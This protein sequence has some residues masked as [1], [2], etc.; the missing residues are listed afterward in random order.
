[1]SR[2]I[3]RLLVTASGLILVCCAYALYADA[4]ESEIVKG[5]DLTAEV[6]LI[7][8]KSGS[9]VA[10]KRPRTRIVA[11]QT[12]VGGTVLFDP[13]AASNEFEGGRIWVAV[14]DISR[15]IEFDTQERYFGRLEFDNLRKTASSLQKQLKQVLPGSEPYQSL[16][17]KLQNVSEKLA[18]YGNKSN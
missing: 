5:E 4:S 14:D 13:I 10:V 16:E 1:M 11:G 8:S 6:A 18:E 12:F 9:S 2:Y 7:Q 15:I 17:S 3:S